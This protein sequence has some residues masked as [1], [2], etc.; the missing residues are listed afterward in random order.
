VVKAKRSGKEKLNFINKLSPGADMLI[1][2][3]W[4]TYLCVKSLF[5]NDIRVLKVDNSAEDRMVH[6]SPRDF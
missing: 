5:N 2:N 3:V 6:R 4:F 1:P